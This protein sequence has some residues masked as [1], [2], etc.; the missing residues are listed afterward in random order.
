MFRF[1]NYKAGDTCTTRV[2]RICTD[3]ASFGKEYDG[4]TSTV[5]ARNGAKLCKSTRNQF[6]FAST[7]RDSRSF[8]SNETLRVQ[9]GC[10]I[11]LSFSKIQLGP[12]KPKRNED[13]H[14]TRCSHCKTAAAPIPL[15]A[16]RVPRT[17]FTR[18]LEI[19]PR[20][21]LGFLPRCLGRP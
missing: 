11:F 21:A 12:V 20:L 4:V 14:D 13:S 17:H 1:Y 3:K 9:S 10:S 18:E 6:L 5:N 15:S 8:F 2:P 7:S 16:A 19:R